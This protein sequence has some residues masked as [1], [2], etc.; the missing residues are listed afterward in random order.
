MS[1][2]SNDNRLNKNDF[3]L[4]FCCCCL[5]D[6]LFVCLFLLLFFYRIAHR[7]FPPPHISNR[8]IN[9][10]KA[11]QKEHILFRQSKQMYK[12]TWGSSFL[13]FQHL[14]VTQNVMQNNNTKVD[15]LISKLLASNNVLHNTL[16]ENNNKKVSLRLFFS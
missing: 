12:R 16:L 8:D 4:L 2:Q 9:K 14:A 6:C 3:V 10:Y 5:F 1:E 7:G 15:H 13:G 11:I